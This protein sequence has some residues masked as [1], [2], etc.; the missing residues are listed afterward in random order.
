[1]TGDLPAPSCSMDGLAGLRSLLILLHPLTSSSFA[2]LYNSS[3]VRSP[4]T[5]FGFPVPGRFAAVRT[6]HDDACLPSGC[7]FLG[8]VF[9]CAT[10]L[11]AFLNVL[12]LSLV[13]P[14]PGWHYVILL[15][16][17]ERN[18]RLILQY[19]SALQRTFVD[20]IAPTRTF[21]TQAR[22]PSKAMQS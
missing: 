22:A 12:V 6:L 15:P 11:S 14:I 1:M 8:P 2:R 3:R 4:S 19:R 13:F 18:R 10:F 21:G 16:Y 5:T 17:N 20:P 7:N 9:R